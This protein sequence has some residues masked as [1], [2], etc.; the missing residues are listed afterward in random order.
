MRDQKRIYRELF[1]SNPQPMFIYAM[2]TMEFLA[3]NDASV[4]H[5]GYSCHEFLQMTRRDV[6]SPDDLPTLTASVGKGRDKLAKVDV[7]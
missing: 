6:H 7:W 2:E 1:E 3:V 5:Y 4:E